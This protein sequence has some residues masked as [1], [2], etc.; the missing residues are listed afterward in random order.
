[1]LLVS[2][3]MTMPYFLLFVT[4]ALTLRR[5]EVIRFVH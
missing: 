4:D 3:A 5:Y 1:M 2:T